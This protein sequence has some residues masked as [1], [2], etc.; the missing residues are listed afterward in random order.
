[1]DHFHKWRRICYSFAFM[2]MRPTDL[3]LVLNMFWYFA[4]GSEIRKAY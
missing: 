2:L 1:M 4:S 3:T